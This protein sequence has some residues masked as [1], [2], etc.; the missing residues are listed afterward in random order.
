MIGSDLPECHLQ[1]RAPG[2]RWLVVERLSVGTLDPFGVSL[3]EVSLQVR[4]GEIVGIAGVSG[5]GQKEL[6]SALSGETLSDPTAIQLR[7]PVGARSA[8]RRRLGLGF[9]PEERLG[10][11]GSACARSSGQRPVT[12]SDH[13]GARRIHPP[14]EYARS[15]AA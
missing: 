10:R 6:L 2:E 7:Q 15:R 5:N 4:G 12:G 8:R 9:V 3:R 14:R 11:G 13:D 1:P